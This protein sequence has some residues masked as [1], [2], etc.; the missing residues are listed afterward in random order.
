MDTWLYP[1]SMWT[2]K[3]FQTL[4]S[5]SN[6]NVQLSSQDVNAAAPIF[7]FN[8]SIFMSPQRKKG[9]VGEGI[10]EWRDDIHILLVFWIQTVRESKEADDVC[11]WCQS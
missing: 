8:W 6:R 7:G 5:F 9:E 10:C 1:F 3:Y 2:F 4:S 11:Y